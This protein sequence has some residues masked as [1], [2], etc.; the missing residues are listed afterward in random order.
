MPLNLYK[1]CYANEL[2]ITGTTISPYAFPRAA[3]IMP[4]MQLDDFT[5]AIYNLDD[6]EEAFLAQVSGKYLKILIRC[7][8]FEGE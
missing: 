7:N 8:D 5:T 1:Y 2:T 6:A 3:Q 4:R